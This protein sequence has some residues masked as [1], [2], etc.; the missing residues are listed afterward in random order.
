[1]DLHPTP[2]P[3]AQPRLCY[4]TP[5]HRGDLERFELLRHSLRMFSP[6]TPHHVLID[7]EDLAVFRERVGH[8][9]GVHLVTSA[10][11][12]PAALERRRQIRKSWRGRL[13]QRI[14]WRTNMLPDPLNGWRLQQLLKIHFLK[15][16]P[17]EAA[18]FMDS[19]IV[20]C[21]PTQTQDFFDGQALRMLETPAR[22][23]E[24]HAYDICTY[25]MLRT[26]LLEVR[27]LF[28]YI[29]QAPRFLRSTAQAL[30]E[31]LA[32]HNPRGWEGRFAEMAFPSE[33][34]L[35]GYAARQ[36]QDYRGY[37]RMPGRAEDWVYRLYDA[38]EASLDALL[39]QCLT[40]QGRRGFMLIQS[41]MEMPAARYAGKVKAL[42]DRLQRERRQ[43]R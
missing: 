29:H 35:L 21:R 16:C 20:L 32:R 17:C 28:N 18:V 23:L 9:P 22:T 33:Y 25:L 10:E 36:L 41:N 14:A 3:T 19:D 37:S 38:D 34:A 42:L 7:T 2:P 1:M 11:L 26:P 24:D 40:E 39:A 27:P 12:L 43:A 5:S 13:M 8:E 4:I 30:V 31:T 6:G 15:D